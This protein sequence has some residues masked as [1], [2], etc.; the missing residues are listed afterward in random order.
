MLTR[1]LFWQLTCAENQSI[2]TIQSG[3]H[4]I[5]SLPSLC[6]PNET[7]YNCE[8]NFPFNSRVST[9]PFHCP[10]HG[11]SLSRPTTLKRGWRLSAIKQNNLKTR[12]HCGLL[13]SAIKQ[14]NLKAGVGGKAGC[15]L[16]S[17][18][19]ILT[20]SSPLHILDISQ[21]VSYLH[22]RGWELKQLLSWPQ[23]RH[24]QLPV[25]SKEW[26]K[27]HTIQGFLTCWNR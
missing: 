22:F 3:T 8:I 19:L 15:Y 17:S 21:S 11:N 20:S 5:V 16:L 2:R 27:P 23:S 9:L 13:L 7:R 10:A 6:M 18:W 26:F 1:H 4:Q 24:L 12:G 25:I 14:N